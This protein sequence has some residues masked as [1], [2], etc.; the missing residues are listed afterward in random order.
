MAKNDSRK[1]AFQ[2]LFV[3]LVAVLISGCASS[4][5]ESE[6]ISAP[7]AS[8]QS[9]PQQLAQKANVKTF[10]IDVV[11]E[12]ADPSDDVFGDKRLPDFVKLVDIKNV[13][14]NFGKDG[15]SIDIKLHNQIKE[16]DV[17]SNNFNAGS[18]LTY[19]IYVAQ[20]DNIWDDY[21]SKQNVEADKLCVFRIFSDLSDDGKYWSW[22]IVNNELTPY[23]ESPS[24]ATVAGFDTDTLHIAIPS[25]Q[26]YSETYANSYTGRKL[27]SDQKNNI[28]NGCSFNSTMPFYVKV[29]SSYY[30][31]FSFE[32]YAPDKK[33]YGLST[34]YKIN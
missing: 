1:T 25:A 17:R 6:K 15:G 13:N 21:N 11:P 10:Q 4:T 23:K 3:L 16:S 7:T 34:W 28:L 29:Y 12:G 27:W 14:A 19:T 31:Y 33:A 2:L 9:L 24:I 5:K 26:L 8:Q 32:D 30:T 22:V 18:G 20:M